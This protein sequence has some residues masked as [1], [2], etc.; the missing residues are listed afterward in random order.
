MIKD[1]CLLSLP[2]KK[3]KIFLF[4]NDYFLNQ[5]KKNLSFYKLQFIVY[6]NFFKLPTTTYESIH[7]CLSI[8]W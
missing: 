4:V 5:K 1:I 8:H 3:K 2:E 6:G 7:V